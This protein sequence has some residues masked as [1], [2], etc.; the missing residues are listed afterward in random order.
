MHKTTFSCRCCTISPLAWSLRYTIQLK[1]EYGIFHSR[2]LLLFLVP[3]ERMV[4]A[5]SC[6]H[7]LFLI[8]LKFFFMGKWLQGIRSAPWH[9]IFSLQG[10]HFYALQGNIGTAL[11]LSNL[12]GLLVSL[13][14]IP[15]FFVSCETKKWCNPLASSLWLG[16][17]VLLCLPILLNMHNLQH[18]TKVPP[19]PFLFLMFYAPYLDTFLLN[20]FIPFSLMDSL[21]FAHMYSCLCWFKFKAIYLVSKKGFRVSRFVHSVYTAK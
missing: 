1:K 4:C 17:P 12:L 8:I 9:V 15:H 13:Y 19:F 11:L 5:A 7:V 14:L 18:N 6:K 16:H 21:S 3:K 2:D 20:H 10:V